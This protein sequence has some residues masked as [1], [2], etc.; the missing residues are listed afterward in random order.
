MREMRAVVDTEHVL[1]SVISRVVDDSSP[2]VSYL[3]TYHT[4]LTHNTIHR[5][6][7]LLWSVSSPSVT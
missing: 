2:V 3:A 5:F 6:P 4:S 1:S 7:C